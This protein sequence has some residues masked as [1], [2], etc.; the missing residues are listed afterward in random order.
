VLGRSGYSG[1]IDVKCDGSK[2]VKVRGERRVGVMKSGEW[3]LVEM[4]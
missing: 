2:E 4:M 1:K 3:R